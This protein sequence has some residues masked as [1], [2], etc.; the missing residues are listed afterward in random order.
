MI[1]GLYTSATAMRQGIIRQEMTANNLANAGTTGFKRDRFFAEELIA[2]QTDKVTTD[3]LSSQAG[4]WTE[5]SQGAFVPTSAGLDFALQSEGFFVVSDG[6]S[7]FYTR[8]GHFERNSEGQLVDLQG[9]TVQGEGG[10]VTLPAG[11]VTSSADGRL[12]VDGV[13]VDRLRVVAF[14][15]PQSLQK[16]SGSAFTKSPQ[17]ASEVPVENPVVRQGFLESSN[18]D[19]VKEMVEMISTARNYEINAK[20]LTTQDA[21]LQHSVNEVGRV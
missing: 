4:K 13:P 11:L 17:T 12:S 14:D 6:Q 18:V 2:A 8:D 15:N 9:R 10:N 20:L 19:T 21:T 1:K 5:Y 3:P 7:E 16:A